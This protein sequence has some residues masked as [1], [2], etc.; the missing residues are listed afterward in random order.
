M[1]SSDTH[2]YAQAIF[3]LC[4]FYMESSW[5]NALWWKQFSPTSS[6]SESY[7]KGYIV[8]FSHYRPSVSTLLLLRQASSPTMLCTIAEIMVSVYSI[9]QF[10]HSELG[11]PEAGESRWIA[12]N[13][14]DGNFL[15]YLIPSADLWSLENRLIKITEWFG[16]ERTLKLT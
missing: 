14:G 1:P 6:L 16:L 8:H 9:S 3:T 7:R 13:S 5:S 4:F 11:Y 15:L 10:L 2:K 12:E